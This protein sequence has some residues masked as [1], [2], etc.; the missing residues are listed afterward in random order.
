MEKSIIIIGGGI[1][2]LSAGCYGQMNGCRTQVFEMHDKTGGVCTGWKR[3]GYTIDGCLHW[4]VGTNPSNSFYPIWEELGVIQGQTIIDH[5]QFMRVEVEGGKAFTLYTNLDRLEQHMKELAPEDRDTI[6]ELIKGVRKCTKMNLPVEKAAE[7]YGPID[8]LKM[9]PHLGF[10]KKWSKLTGRDFTNRIKNP[11]LREALS[12]AFL[13][14]FF[15]LIFMLLTFAWLHNK[16]AGYLI[17]GALEIAGAMERRYIGL[18]G[19]IHSK[20]RVNE[21]LVEN[22]KAVGVRLEDGTEHRGDIVISAADGRTTIFDMLGGKYLNDEIKGYYDQPKLFDPLIYIG[23]GV[24]R[25]FDDEPSSVIGIN[26]PLDKPVTIAGE[27]QRR[28]HVCMYNF[29]PTM[30]PKGKT[31]LKVQFNTDYDYWKQLRQEPERYKAEKEQIA[32]Q[33]V[34][35]LDQRYPGLAAQVEM[36]DIATPITWE[37]YTGNWRGSYEG[38]LPTAEMFTTHMSKT[39]PGLENFYMVGQWVEP[40]GGL[41]TAAKSGRDAMQIICK[42]DKKPFV[43]TKP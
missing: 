18:G 16:E 15:P 37:R 34:A 35:L 1:A 4:L 8:G 41:P 40:G 43:T 13:G 26:Y 33:V 14:D 39:L 42:K 25:S 11:F 31:V 21:I 10:F 30:A 38:W 28:L 17:G 19:A 24:A 29:D 36:R 32:D 20:S 2:G 5:E 27:E 22:D 3:K 9:L 23:L 7:L 12:V 6:E